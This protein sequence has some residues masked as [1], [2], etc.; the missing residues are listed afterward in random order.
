LLRRAQAFFLKVIL[1]RAKNRQSA[2]R[3]PA[4]RRLRIAASTSSSVKSGCFAI[5]ASSQFACFSNGEVL[6]PCRLAVEL[7]ASRQ[8]CSHLTAALAL[9]SKC[10][11]ASRREAPLST[12]AMTRSRISAEY[13]F[14]IVQ[15]PKAESMPIDS[16]INSPLGIL[17]FYS[18]GTC[19][20]LI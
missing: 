10:S 8:R 18:A 5:K 4:I 7:P 20:S 15:P 2:V 16:L 11:A 17:R 9:I 13:G 6:P 19:S 14:G 1:C 12:L 3:L